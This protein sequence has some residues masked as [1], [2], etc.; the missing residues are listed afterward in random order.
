MTAASPASV[1]PVGGRR[2]LPSPVRLPGCPVPHSPEALKP[3]RRDTRMIDPMSP[4]PR[5]EELATRSG[6]T[7]P[8]PASVDG[9]SGSTPPVRPFTVPANEMEEGGHR[10]PLSS[11][12][13]FPPLGRGGHT[14]PA[15][16]R[17]WGGG[18]P[19]DTSQRPNVTRP[20]HLNHSR[21]T[22]RGR[23]AS[24]GTAREPRS[25]SR[26]RAP[27]P[28]RPVRARVRR[29]RGHARVLRALRGSGT[30]A[31]RVSSPEWSVHDATEPFLKIPRLFKSLHVRGTCPGRHRPPARGV[32]VVSPTHRRSSQQINGDVILLEK[33]FRYPSRIC[34]Y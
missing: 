14:L 27:R 3:I 30:L 20:Q 12:S 18:W 9:L 8:S 6:L 22:P 1:R 5:G 17:G 31:G 33:R 24:A 7:C 25:R 34:Y 2:H 13:L 4:R 21:P 19:C 11:G 10:L 16:R 32:C 26:R 28:G 29:A 15:A 23:C